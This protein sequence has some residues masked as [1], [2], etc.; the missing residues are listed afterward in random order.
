MNVDSY[1]KK[2]PYFL[3]T[4]E[5]PAKTIYYF[6]ENGMGSFISVDHDFD[7]D[8][9]DPVTSNVQR[10]DFWEET[11]DWLRKTLYEAIQ[12][13]Y[14]QHRIRYTIAHKKQPLDSLHW[15][16]S[17][18]QKNGKMFYNHFFALKNT[19]LSVEVIFGETLLPFS[20]YLEEYGYELTIE[21]EKNDKIFFHITEK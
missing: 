12:L 4:E 21:K 6:N 20:R 5:T 2:H 15:S 3:K 8:E 14:Q 9:E 18:L 16:F 1:L 7:F 17:L 11:S 10:S 13:Y 19:S